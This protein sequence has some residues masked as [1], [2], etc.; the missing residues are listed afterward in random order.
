MF[1]VRSG[2]VMPFAK[3]TDRATLPGN[4]AARETLPMPVWSARLD[5]T[6]PPV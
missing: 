4:L 1:G 5:L 6:L 2:L 3:V